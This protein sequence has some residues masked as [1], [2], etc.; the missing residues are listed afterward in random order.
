[1]DRILNLA[2][3]VSDE[4]AAA[5]NVQINPVVEEDSEVSSDEMNQSEENEASTGDQTQ[6]EE[7][8]AETEPPEETS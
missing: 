7:N 3:P 2:P 1:M 4:L 8:D 6:S 5:A